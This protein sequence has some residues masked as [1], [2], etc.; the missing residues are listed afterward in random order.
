MVFMLGSAVN[1]S[2]LECST[3][4]CVWTGGLI[5]VLDWARHPPPSLVI[6]TAVAAG[7][8]VLTRGLSPLWLAIIAVSLVAVA[9]HSLPLLLRR[10]LVRVAAAVVTFV[11]LVGVVYIVW[12]HAL[13]VTAGAVGVPVGSSRVEVVEL[14]IGRTDAFVQQFVGSIGWAETNSPVATLG[15]WM[16][17]AS[18][19]VLFALLTSQ[20]RHL[21]VVIALMFTSLALPTALIVSQSSNSGLVWQARDGYPLYVGILLVSGGVSG[22][23]RVVTANSPA[24]A[25]ITEWP[26]RRLAFLMVATIAVVQLSDFV[27]ALRRYTVGLGS[28]L[29]PFVRVP[30]GWTPPM[31]PVDLVI[32]ETVASAAF[33]WWILHLLRGNKVTDPVRPKSVPLRM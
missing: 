12:A 29:N 13:N 4:I 25:V 9:P 23:K 24:L 8:M 14:A 20:R 18:V 27:W 32:V 17:T 30:G 19:V 3:A 22:R 2:G 33:A 16:L 10:Q 21:I 28:V 26:T 15:L 11:S 5:L 1:P 6:A 31:P 7:V